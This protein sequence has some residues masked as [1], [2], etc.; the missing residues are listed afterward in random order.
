M[1]LSRTLNGRRVRHETASAISN[2]FSAGGGMM[3][4]GA[5]E[6]KAVRIARIAAVFPALIKA[7]E[8]GPVYVQE[9]A[10]ASICKLLYGVGA[11]LTVA[12]RVS[13]SKR[14][15]RSFHTTVSGTLLKATHEPTTSGRVMDICLRILSV[16]CPDTHRRLVGRAM[17]C[18]T[19]CGL[20]VGKKVFLPS[21]A[22]MMAH[23]RPQKFALDG[24]RLAKAMANIQNSIK[25]SDDPRNRYLMDGDSYFFVRVTMLMMHSMGQPVHRFGRGLCPFPPHCHPSLVESCL[26]CTGAAKR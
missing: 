4:D 26:L 1:T 7:F 25:S 24:V 18:A 5:R 21:D 6:V 17:E 9:Q 22:G 8:M 2:Y 10:L 3:D 23:A 14:L 19:Y 13:L 12:Q 11:F 20:P 15:R 16:P